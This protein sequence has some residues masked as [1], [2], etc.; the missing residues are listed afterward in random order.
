MKNYSFL[1]SVLLVLGIISCGPKDEAIRIEKHNGKKLYVCDYF[2]VKDTPV[3]VQLSDMVESLEVIKL[4][5]DTNAIVGEGNVCVS[6]NYLLVGSNSKG[7]IKLFNR[8]GKYLNDI[9]TF[10]RGPGEYHSVY[11]MQMDEKAGRI[12]LMPW[13]TRYIF[14]YNL[15]GQ[16][17]KPILLAGGM[18]K[19]K[20][21][22]QDTFVKVMALPFQ[23]AVKWAAFYQTLNGK[24]LD[25]VPAAPYAVTYDYSNE[26]FGDRHNNSVYFFSWIGR[27][28]SL[29][30]Y[31]TGNNTLTPVF[32]VDFGGIE[33]VPMH[34]LH[35]TGKYFWF[36]VTEPKQVGE[37]VYSTTTNKNVLVDKEKGT[38][39]SSYVLDNDLLGFD[40]SLWSFS[41]GYYSASF[42]P[43]VF[44]EKLEKA[45]KRDDLKPEVQKRIEELLAGI[46]EE[47]NN[48]IVIGKMKE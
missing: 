42:L 17:T 14:T 44:K 9:G 15:K 43:H 46:D 32:T 30:H 34:D 18:P 39:T 27:Q 38:A 1:L 8:E 35:E 10:G 3:K 47:D 11:D 29:Y 28:D 25:S 23:K 33:K 21:A 31:E 6:D 45:L 26:L 37:N 19:G 24:L 13:Q 36:S 5:N 40:I 7:P 20:F 4:D 16:F 48:Y 2:K 12:Y 41:D 22:V